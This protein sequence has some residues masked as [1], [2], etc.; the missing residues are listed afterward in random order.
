MLT[1]AGMFEKSF[2]RVGKN[3]SA[4][5]GKNQSAAVGKNQSAPDAMRTCLAATKRRAEKQA[6]SRDG[7]RRAGPTP[8]DSSISVIITAAPNFSIFDPGACFR[9]GST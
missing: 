3:Q 1:P 6:T 5:V 4:A 2:C 9:F 8:M 7:K